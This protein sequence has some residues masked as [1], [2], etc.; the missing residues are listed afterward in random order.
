M[1]SLVSRWEVDFTCNGQLRIVCLKVYYES[2]ED[3]TTQEMIY[4]DVTVKHNVCKT[5]IS[6][7]VEYIIIHREHVH[8]LRIH[9]LRIKYEC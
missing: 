1:K 6:L 4:G 7:Y 3:R 2:I 9:E 8:S 5:S